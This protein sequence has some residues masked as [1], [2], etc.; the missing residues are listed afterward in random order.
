[1]STLVIAE[2]D[3]DSMNIATLNSVA[4]A[5]SL[6]GDIDILV[7]GNACQGAADQA[8]RVAGISKIIVAD[9]TVYSLSLIHI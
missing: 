2:H 3:N 8:A 6:G 1:M 9:N 7:V 5:Q 4:A